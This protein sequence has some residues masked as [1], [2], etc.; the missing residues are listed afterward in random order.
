L[1]ANQVLAPRIVQLP[2]QPLGQSQPVIG[3]AQQQ[4][5]RVRSNPL[6]AGLDLDGAIETRLK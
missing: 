6:V 1:I 5:A 2:G 4:Q 3:L